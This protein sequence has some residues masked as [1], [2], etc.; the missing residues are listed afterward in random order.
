MF[1]QIYG[2]I[3]YKVVFLYCCF[4]R[5][6]SKWFISINYSIPQRG[7]MRDRHPYWCVLVQM[8]YYPKWGKSGSSPRGSALTISSLSLALSRITRVILFW[9][10]ADVLPDGSFRLGGSSWHLGMENVMVP[11]HQVCASRKKSTRS[12]LVRWECC[13]AQLHLCC[14]V[15]C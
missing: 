10:D 11:S 2:M 5:W 1:L 7:Q 4:H 9:L 15:W 13:L 14:L 6:I 8:G 12:E 3:Y